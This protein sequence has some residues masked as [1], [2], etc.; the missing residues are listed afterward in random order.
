MNSDKRP[1]CSV[2]ARDGQP[3]RTP[4]LSETQTLRNQVEQQERSQRA[5]VARMPHACIHVRARAG[6]APGCHGGTARRRRRQRAGY[7]GARGLRCAR[8][9]HAWQ[10]RRRHAGDAIPD[11]RRH[12]AIVTRIGRQPA[13]E[14]PARSVRQRGEATRRSG[15][16][17]VGGGASRWRTGGWLGAN[18]GQRQGRGSR[19]EGC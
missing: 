17:A 7:S 4:G 13:R 14:R 12:V 8:R 9:Q 5:H 6:A 2:G 3:S 11:R 10:R 15:A 16:G 1:I 19:D 18:L